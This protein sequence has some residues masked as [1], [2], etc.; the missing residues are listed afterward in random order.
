MLCFVPLLYGYVWYVCFY[1]RKTVFS[2]VFAITEEGYG[3]VSGALAYVFVGFWDGTM[4]ANFHMR[5]IMLV[6]RAREEYES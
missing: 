2:S 5:S 3:P 4:L 6:L 1:V